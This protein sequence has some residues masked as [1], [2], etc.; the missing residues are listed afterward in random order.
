MSA[1]CPSVSL[2]IP[3]LNC[4]DDVE[5]CIASLRQQEYPSDHVQIIVADNGSSDRTV[6][7]LKKLQ[8]ECVIR[9]DRG[10]SRALNAGLQSARG[11]I[12][13]TT[14][15]SC[16]P[17]PDWIQDDRQV[18]RGFQRRLRGRGYSAH[19][20]RLQHCDPVPVAKRLYVAD[21]CHIAQDFPF[22]PFADGA[23]ASFR[24]SLFDEIGGFDETFIKGADV[25]MCYRMFVMTRYKLVF[26]REAIVWET[27]EPNLAS[28][29]AA[30]IQDGHRFE[31]AESEV[32]GFFSQA[33]SGNPIET[34]LL[35]GLGAGREVRLVGHFPGSRKNGGHDGA[36]AHVV[37]Q[38]LGRWYS[39]PIS[40]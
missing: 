12:V 29:I 31:P 2:I 37:S 6:E 1:Y 38:S 14:D 26:C 11:E 10:R 5:G 36:V 18:F 22:L 17:L 21:A 13:C 3:A 15:M 34:S 32:S 30:K 7:L 25:E 20:N 33:D 27:G 28:P 19:R 35:D 4:E 9:P 8:V 16:R 39:G 40:S 24:R 23:N